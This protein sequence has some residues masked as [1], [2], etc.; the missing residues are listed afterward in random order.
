MKGL[1]VLAGFTAEAV[2]VQPNAATTNNTQIVVL[3]IS[4]SPPKKQLKTQS[5]RRRLR[6]AAPVNPLRLRK[7]VSEY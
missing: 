4:V 2:P 3:F 7:S 1:F 6:A 5:L